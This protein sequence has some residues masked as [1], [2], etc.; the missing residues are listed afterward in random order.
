MNNRTTVALYFSV[1]HQ[2]AKLTAVT[3]IRHREFLTRAIVLLLVLELTHGRGD[4][5]GPIPHDR[6]DG[7]RGIRKPA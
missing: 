5:G 7:E 6:T 2:R 3:S 4:A 1:S